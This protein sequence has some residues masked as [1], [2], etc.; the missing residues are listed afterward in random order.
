MTTSTEA[1]SDTA[2]DADLD[3]GMTADQS[4][5]DDAGASPGA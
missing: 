5:A 3:G 1:D 4:P 2:P